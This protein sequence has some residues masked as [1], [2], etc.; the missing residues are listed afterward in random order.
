MKEFCKEVGVPRD[1]V[2]DPSGDQAG[3]EVKQL[4]HD[5]AMNLKVLEENTQHANLAELHV[6][7]M[8]SVISGDLRE[9]GCP[10]VFGAVPL[11][12]GC[13]CTMPL[14]AR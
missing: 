2:V 4:C 12:G 3:D 13:V 6:G 8:K 7:I 11:S 5:V 9:M 10:L 1:L 14:Q